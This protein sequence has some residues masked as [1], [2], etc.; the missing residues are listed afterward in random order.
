MFYR[1]VVNKIIGFRNLY[2]KSVPSNANL[3]NLSLLIWCGVI[4]SLALIGV[5]YYPLPEAKILYSDQASHIAATLSLWHDQDLIYTL[6]DLMRFR[7][8]LPS[9]TGPRGAFLKVGYDQ[10]L[11]YAKPILYALF[12]APFV[13]LFGL[14]GFLLFNMLCVGVIGFISLKILNKQLGRINSLLLIIGLLVFS[15]YL[16]WAPVSHPDILIATLLIAGGYFLLSK[17]DE[18]EI[19]YKIIGALLLGLAMYEKPT[20]IIFSIA[21]LVTQISMVNMRSFVVLCIAVFFAWS[22]PTSVHYFQDGNILS[23]QGLRFYVTSLS[24]VGTYPLEVNWSGVPGDGTGMTEKIFNAAT[25]FDAIMS[26]VELLP[27]KFLDLIV[28]RQTG[29]LVYFPVSILL[30]GLLLLGLTWRSAILAGAFF[31]YLV[32]YW[33]AFP[34]NGF[35]GAGTYGPRYTMQALPILL[36]SF[37]YF[38]NKT[39]LDKRKLKAGVF[40]SAAVTGLVASFYFQSSVYPPKEDNV[41]APGNFLISP[42][43]E[44][45]PLEDSLLSQVYLLMPTRFSDNVAYKGVKNAV[46][47]KDASN[48]NCYN[49]TVSA[50]SQ[51]KELVLFQNGSLNEIPELSVYASRNMQVEFIDDGKVV[52]SKIVKRS[53]NTNFKL[54]SVYDKTYHDR[55]KGNVR[56]KVISVRSKLLDASESDLPGLLDI[57]F[58]KQTE[59]VSSEYVIGNTVDIS[60]FPDNGIVP[61]FCWQPDP[62]KYWSSGYVAGFKLHMSE[63]AMDNM[64]VK[65]WFTPFYPPGNDPL[66]IDLYANGKYVDRYLFDRTELG[67]KHISAILKKEIVSGRSDLELLFNVLNPSHAGNNDYRNLGMAVQKI[68]LSN[69]VDSKR[70]GN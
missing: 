3:D 70:F 60:Q 18:N 62:V 41:K 34:T 63:V 17:H 4:F 54:A 64:E 53:E 23:Y 26:N 36:I 1:E 9:E 48:D 11:Y 49:Y 21:L 44:M 27:A 35:G 8:E 61:K 52:A 69:Y 59:Q 31:A 42:I 51:T 5:E 29:L 24:V 19:T 38:N 45:F 13:G 67:D 25:L 68:H 66:E 14:K 28:G 2:F 12:A 37:I 7:N 43:G 33:L 57:K 16:A 65:L 30:C 47:R 6:T 50:E 22:I 46:F 55:I 10:Q 15:P 40:A 58:S 56:W 32:I 39:L 20:F